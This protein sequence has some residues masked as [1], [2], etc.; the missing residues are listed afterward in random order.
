MRK[1][2]Q[3]TVLLHSQTCTARLMLSHRKLRLTHDF[4]ILCLMPDFETLRLAGVWQVSYA[5][6]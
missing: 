5:M 1:S 3:K 6:F 4:E 2:D